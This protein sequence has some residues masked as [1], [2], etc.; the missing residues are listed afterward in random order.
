MVTGGSDPKVIYDQHAGRFVAMVQEI[1]GSGTDTATDDVS[2]MY[3]AVSD[4]NDPNGT[5]YKFSFDSKIQVNGVKNWADYPGF[6]RGR[7]RGLSDHQLLSVEGSGGATS[8]LELFPKQAFIA[9]AP[10]PRR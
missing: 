2:R 8:R 4:D 10:Q 1:Q 7:K 6:C 3:V 5:W 9:A